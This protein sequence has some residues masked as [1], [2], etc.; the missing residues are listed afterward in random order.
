MGG[1]GAVTCPEKVIYSK[2]STVS[3]DP[4]GRASDH[5]IYNPDLQ[6]WSRTP[7]VQAG[8][9]EWD[10]DPPPPRMGSGP[11]T[12]GSQASRT[13]HARAWNKTQ[14][15]VRCRHVSRPGPV[16]IYSYSPLRRGPVAATWHTA[17]GLSQRAE[18]SMTPL[19]YARLRI[20]YT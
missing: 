8:P 13:E 9:L 6:G 16:R 17:R 20:H 3:P 15:G 11:P 19:G 10:L 4:H 18:H 12:M 14:A 5:G 2:A 1:S 7:R